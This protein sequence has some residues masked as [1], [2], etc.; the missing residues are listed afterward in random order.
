MNPDTA[1]DAELL[2]R[3]TQRG[4]HAAFRALAERYSGLVYHTALR[5]TGDVELAR[6]VCQGVFLVLARKAARLDAS[7]GLAGWL[8]RAAVLEAR[9]VG[10]REHRRREALRA[11]EIAMNHESSTHAAADLHPALPHLDRAMDRLPRP[12]REVL[13][14]HYYQG[15]TYGEIAH[16][17]QETEAAVQRRASRA[18]EKLSVA[19]R[20]AG[21]AVP[22]TAL[23]A[24]LSAV[25]QSPAPAGVVPALP[26]VS[27]AP[28]MSVSWLAKAAALVAAGGLSGAASYAF[29]EPGNNA[30]VSATS[31]QS[32]SRS[33][34]GKNDAATVIPPPSGPRAEWQVIAERAADALRSASGS[35]DQARAAW[36][37][38]ALAMDELKSALHWARTLP[39]ERLRARL[40]GVI[41]SLRA[42]E[43]PATAWTEQCELFDSDEREWRENALLRSAERICRLL[44]QRDPAQCLAR[45]PSLEK[46]DHMQDGASV[47]LKELLA[48]QESRET[49]LRRIEQ[50]PDAPAR[51]AAAKA[52][53]RFGKPDDI[54]PWIMNM[55]LSEDKARRVP[56]SLVMWRLEGWEEWDAALTSWLVGLPVEQAE[57]ARGSMLERLLKAPEEE[58]LKFSKSLTDSVLRRAVQE[59]L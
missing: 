8:H 40:G 29:T 9:G 53:L 4:D 10:H 2:R 11:L 30:P 36:H 47:V 34:A 35:L 59:S 50:T 51:E 48:T 23:I 15:W 17:S 20:R 16:R 43:D 42:Q 1:M 44:S 26:A 49:L 25:L 46:A 31:G 28:A 22:A 37:L 12:D 39:D 38:K 45:L 5:S 7:G 52:A 21:V 55:S 58:R 13:L 18:V 24:G 6:D 54:V 27:A 3:F 19:L 41:L 57:Q 14:A 32:D 56:L 33:T